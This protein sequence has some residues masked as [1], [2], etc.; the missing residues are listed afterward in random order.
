M[1]ITVRDARPN[2]ANSIADFN[3]RMA[4]ETEGRPLDPALVDPGVESVLA[5]LG[6]GRY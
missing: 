1:N 2:D 4:Q 6:K 5:D 3:S